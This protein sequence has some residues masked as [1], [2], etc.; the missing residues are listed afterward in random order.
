MAKVLKKIVING[1]DYDLPSGGGGWGWV[2]LFDIPTN[3]IDWMLYCNVNNFHI[4]VY[5]SG[6]RYNISN[7]YEMG[8]FYDKWNNVE[9]LYTWSWGYI[10]HW[11]GSSYWEILLHKSNWDELIIADRNV[12]A[13]SAWTSSSSYW[14]YYAVWEW[15]PPTWYHIPSRTEI[16]SLVSYYTLITW[17]QTWADS[18][19]LMPLAWYSDWTSKQQWSWWFY[20]SSTTKSWLRFYMLAVNSSNF[21]TADYVTAMKWTIRPFKN[22]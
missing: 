18:N 22:T 14:G 20:N 2:V 7:W 4:Y 12:W 11:F 16:E 9:T 17:G 13:S 5:Y 3:P 21:S 10:A 15:T 6:T 19:L 1:V 8:S